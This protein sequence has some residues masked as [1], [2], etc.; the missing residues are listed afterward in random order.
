MIKQHLQ[1]LMLEDDPLDAELIK[2]Q[3]NHLD[4]Y[5]CKVV[6]VTDKFGF[7]REIANREPDIVL[8]DFNLPQYSGLDALSD[9]KA[10]NLLVPFIFVTGALS[11]EIAAETI[12]AGAWD[13]VVKDRLLRLPLAI[14]GALQLR[15]QRLNNA[16]SEENNR[17]LSSAL[18]QSPVHVLIC[19]I[20]G[21]IEYVNNRFAEITGFEQEETIGVNFR[22]FAS[23]IYSET[24][25]FNLWETLLKGSSWRGEMQAIK[26]DGT[27]FWESVSLS[28]MFGPLGDVIHF[29]AVKEDI[30]HR[31][32]IEQ[33]LAEAKDRAERSDKLKE[34]FLQNLSHEIRT[35]MNAIVGFSGL[36]TD[37]SLDKA[38][39]LEYALIVQNSSA[40][41]LTIVSDIVAI[42]RIQTGQERLITRPLFVN[43]IIDSLY[44]SIKPRTVDKNL[45]LIAR[46]DESN[47]MPVIVSDE[48]K[49]RQIL[50]NLLQNAI[51]FTHAGSVEFGYELKESTITFFVRDTGIG[52]PI[53]S[54][55]HIFERFRQAD[56]SFSVKYGGTGLGLSISKSYATLM[57]GT[58]SVVS[59]VGKGS[60]FSLTIPMQA[61]PQQNF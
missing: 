3:L 8:S 59:E 18:A 49:L 1:I 34:A 33:D 57:G 27:T 11:E 52:I 21:N 41:L 25:W 48:T 51:K 16:R 38:S 2:A 13:Y 47:P 6:W 32:K 12:K 50:T 7:L 35:P 29:I 56:P 20:G 61:T 26:K 37:P 17:I 4:E 58:I 55:D 24:F 54:I 9:L 45:L 14:R 10:H 60:T 28:P 44:V 30:T 46:K 19:N 42:A 22:Q 31:K 5:E 39:L 43:D 23:D 15:E 36:L 53:D 40:Q